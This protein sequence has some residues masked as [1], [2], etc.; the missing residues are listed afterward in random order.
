[1]IALCAMLSDAD[2]LD[3]IELWGRMKTDW[4]RRFLK[5]ENGIPSQDTF[6]RIFRVA[7]ETQTGGLGRRYPDEHVGSHRYDVR[8][9]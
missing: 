8:V 7:L 6:L 1:M 9:Q 4:L 3:E 2:S 5:L